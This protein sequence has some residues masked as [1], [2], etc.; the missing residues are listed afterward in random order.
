MSDYTGYQDT[1]AQNSLP[2]PELLPD[3][4]CSELSYPPRLNCGVELLDKMVTSGHADSP[5][6]R[7]NGEVVTYQDTL[8]LCNKIA[9][10][11]VNDLGMVSGAR[12]LLRGPNTLML[13]ACWLAV[14][15]AGGICVTTMPLLRSRELHY[16]ID[17]A[18]VDFCLCDGGFSEEIEKLQ[19][20]TPKLSS[21]LYFN[22]ENPDGLESLISSRSSEFENV[23][24]AGQDISLIAFTSGT[25]GTP[26]ATMHTHQDV[27]VVCD[28]FPKSI[29]KANSSDIF[30]G[31][32]PLAFTFGLGGLLLFP[33]RI[34][35]SIALLEKP[36]AL[37]LLSVIQTEG[38]TVC[39]TSPT[40]YRAM[41][42]RITEFD[43]SSLRRCVSA[44]E[45]LPVPTFDAWESVTDI[46]IIDGIG[47]T[48]MLHIFI[49]AADDQIVPG[50][51]GKVVPGY[52]AA[53]LD[54]QGNPVPAGT[55][56]L[57]AVKGPTGCRY[58]EDPDRQRDYV[59]NGWNMTGDAYVQDQDG[60][61]WFHARADDM[62]ISSG[63]NISGIEVEAAL[64]THPDVS[65]CGVVG[66]PDQDRG[67][68]VKAFVVLRE[69]VLADHQKTRELQDY[70]KSQIAPYKYPR[71]IE[72]VSTLPRTETGK[73]QRFQL[74]SALNL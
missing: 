20:N 56:G 59:K 5:L 11:L 70:V 46:R 74:R 64:L 6:F 18:K 69:G 2:P 38:A 15:K 33:M 49:S 30:V 4:L 22:T 66:C 1:F 42:E 32:P 44:G 63:Y 53:V 9:N 67:H 21:V 16:I 43:L 36:S 41:L 19:K 37:N 8:C 27:I 62:I 35:A 71:A 14:Q 23:D 17:K 40:A 48:E 52:E 72:F 55:V 13:A 65:E 12:V 50:A 73:L 57:L 7:Q 45:P 31:T 60:Y 24:T 54:P 28:L 61:F 58:L 68:I 10:L 25:T 39:F 29:L 26:K 34:G 51:T 3:F 47:A